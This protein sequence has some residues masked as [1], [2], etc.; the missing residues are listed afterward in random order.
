MDRVD[1]LNDVRDGT[2]KT[3]QALVFIEPA[4][5][6]CHVLFRVKG[7]IVFVWYSETVKIYSIID[8]GDFMVRDVKI[9]LEF[10]FDFV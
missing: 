4:Y 1:F 10:T 3:F 8:N 7:V 9:F 5:D 2:D 6:G